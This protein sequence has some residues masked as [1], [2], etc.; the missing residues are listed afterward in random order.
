MAAYTLYHEDGKDGSRISLYI[1]NFKATV[2]KIMIL[3]ALFQIQNLHFSAY[4]EMVSEE[5][6]L[7][8]GELVVIT[9][10]VS[11]EY[12]LQVDELVVIVCCGNNR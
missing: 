9:E 8:V 7:Q 10:M 4:T 1:G 5:Y 6:L 12:L 2:Y 3:S 11:E